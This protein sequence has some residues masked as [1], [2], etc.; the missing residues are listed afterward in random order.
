MF[1]K[2]KAATQMAGML[3]DLPRLQAKL[4]EV[5][6]RLASTKVHGAA[7]GGAVRVIATCDLRIESVTLD[8]SV[9]RG[10]A[11]GSA[12]DAAYANRMVADATNDA[13]S[14]ARA[15]IAEELGRAAKEAGVDL[16][17]QLLEQLG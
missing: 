9:L 15:R 6:E 14:S 12:A 2:L 11:T 3:K 13:L 5:R 16:P 10:I 8:P 1:D 4:A 17:T 7:G